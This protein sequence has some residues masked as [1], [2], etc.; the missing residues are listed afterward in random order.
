[1]FSGSLYKKSVALTLLLQIILSSLVGMV[2]IYYELAQAK[3]EIHFSQKKVASAAIEQVGMFRKNLVRHVREIST[4]LELASDDASAA[5][6]VLERFC[7]EEWF[8]NLYLLDTTGGQIKAVCSPD[9]SKY[10]LIPGNYFSSDSGKPLEVYVAEPGSITKVIMYVGQIVNFDDK[11]TI[12]VAAVDL[13]TTPLISP[14]VETLQ[15]SQYGEGYV[16][17]SSGKPII[18]AGKDQVKTRPVGLS[19][20][21]QEGFGETVRDGTVYMATYEKIPGTDWGVVIEIP[22]NQVLGKIYDL[23]T[24]FLTALLAT[25]I[26]SIFLTVKWVRGLLERVYRIRDSLAEVAAG[27]FDISVKVDGRDELAQLARTFNSMANKIKQILFREKIKL[28][29]EYMLE[30][31]TALAEVAAGTAHEIRNPLTSIKGFTYLLQKKL[32]EG[33]QGWQYAEIIKKEIGHIENIINR[34]LLMASPM[35]PVFKKTNL[36]EI[37]DEVLPV[38]A[39]E[40]VTNRV[41]IETDMDVTIPEVPADQMQIKQLIINLCRNSIQAMPG[42]GK[43]SIKTLFNHRDQTVDLLI[44]DNGAGI[45]PSYL[46]RIADPFFTTKENGTGLGLTVSYRIVQNHQGILQVFSAEG[47]GTAC[48]VKLPTTNRMSEPENA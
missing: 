48:L 41:T 7:E 14:V 42:G 30:K 33:E 17:D 12:L 36:H 18:W 6:E 25:V 31:Y 22:K 39:R 38:I 34:L 24:V 11:K 46:G 47:V 45:S 1:M 21:M 37:V 13:A 43:L 29:K 4:H 23:T 28:E 9:D 44:K 5:M 27:N 16:V 2:V 8:K 3:K 20:L 35:F 32:P 10:A 15:I 19:K 26:V 40:A